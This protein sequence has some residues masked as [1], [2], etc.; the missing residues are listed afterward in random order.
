MCQ[1]AFRYVPIID[2]LGDYPRSLRS[3]SFIPNR[4]AL[5]TIR[6]LLHI[7]E[8]P[9]GHVLDKPNGEVRSRKRRQEEPTPLADG[10]F[11][12]VRLALWTTE[13][14]TRQDW[15]VRNTGGEKEMQHLREAWATLDCNWS[16]DA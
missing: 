10:D 3:I 5:A 4:L 14:L 8:K 16:T 1:T 15:D 9:S 12:W 6:E 7:L 13:G 2:G 11:Q